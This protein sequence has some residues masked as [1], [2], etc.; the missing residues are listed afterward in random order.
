MSNKFVEKRHINHP[1]STILLKGISKRK[2]EK[3]RSWLQ[4]NDRIE[5]CPCHESREIFLLNMTK[6]PKDRAPDPAELQRIKV[7]LDRHQAEMKGERQ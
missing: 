4:T 5:V 3:L 2:L 6:R 7:A 1:R